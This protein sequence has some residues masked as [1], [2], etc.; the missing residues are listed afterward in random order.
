MRYAEAAGV[1]ACACW[2]LWHRPRRLKSQRT[3]VKPTEIEQLAAQVD[4]VYKAWLT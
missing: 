1:F 2:M 3:V 4:A